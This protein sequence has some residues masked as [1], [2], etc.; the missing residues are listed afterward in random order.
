M[1]QCLE[2]R[3]YRCHTYARCAKH[4]DS[5]P[6]RSYRDSLRTYLPCK[7][8]VFPK[9]SVF[10]DINA[11]TEHGTDLALHPN[12]ILECRVRRK[13]HQQIDVAIRAFFLAGARPED[14]KLFGLVFPRDGLYLITLRAYLVK[15]AHISNAII[16][17]KSAHGGAVKFW[18]NR[19]RGRAT[20]MRGRFGA[21][22]RR[23]RGEQ[24]RQRHFA[25]RTRAPPP[26]RR[27]RP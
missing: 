10:N 26:S 12:E 2:Y 21:R 25:G 22:E 4:H 3:L 17:P 18:Q 13:F 24:R 19:D 15:H 11:T 8:R 27:C 14:P 9:D 6:C 1:R 5:L 20:A 16:I 7:T 23:R